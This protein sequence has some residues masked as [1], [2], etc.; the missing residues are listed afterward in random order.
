M[1]STTYCTVCVEALFCHDTVIFR[2][3]LY[4]K[5]VEIDRDVKKSQ[6]EENLWQASVQ[7]MFRKPMSARGFPLSGSEGNG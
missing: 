5:A 6:K 1:L 4:R 3:V 7:E 2:L